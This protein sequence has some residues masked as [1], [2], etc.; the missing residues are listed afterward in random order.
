M[1]SILPVYNESVAFGV[2]EGVTG[3]NGSDRFM[4]QDVS[5]II[6]LRNN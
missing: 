2:F 3:T 4:R 5:T 6:T 1:R